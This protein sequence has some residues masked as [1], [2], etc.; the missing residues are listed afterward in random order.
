SGPLKGKVKRVGVTAWGTKAK[1]GTIAADTR[2]FPF[3]TIMHI[4]GYGYG[5]VEDRGGAIKGNHIDLFFHSHKQA[6]QWGKQT[7]RVRVWLPR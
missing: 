6:L 2:R 7:K 4:E 3:G 5:R 1:R